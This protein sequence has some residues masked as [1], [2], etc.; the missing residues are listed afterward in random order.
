[1]P[2]ESLS[3]AALRVGRKSLAKGY[4]DRTGALMKMAAEL[5]DRPSPDEIHDLR[6][7]A[8]RI[9]VMRK[10]M[11]RTVRNSQ[12][13]KT[14]NLALKSVMK[15]TS[16]LRDLDTLMVTLKSYKGNL[17]NGILVSLENQRSDSAARAKV[18]I[19]ALA[20]V[21][22]GE[23]DTSKLR[24][25]RLS[26]RFRKDVR[27]HSKKASSLLTQVLND[28]SKAVELHSLRKEVKKLRY[29]LEL[30][31]KT[32]ARFSSLA[33]WQDSLGAI[34]DLDVA[35]AYLKGIGAGPGRGAILELQRA[36]RSNYLAFVRA[37]RTDRMQALGEG[38]ALPVG[39]L[40][41]AN[42]GPPQA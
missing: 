9:Q 22:L 21:Q 23:L 30:A 5:P 28:E 27:K 19:G 20:D 31:D 39:A 38:G 15:A 11:S 26:R 18:T 25:K 7:A 37:Y 2:R 41:P 4:A 14:F 12:D 10:L 29:L 34:R 13:S 42:L 32:P 3:M 1:M 6:V 35:I 24:G 8:R 17:P 40:A 16:Q 36:R 33:K